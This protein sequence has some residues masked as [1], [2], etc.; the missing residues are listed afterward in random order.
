MG[1][2]HKF[3]CNH[4]WI[5]TALLGGYLVGSLQIL[6]TNF[7]THA[8]NDPSQSPMLPAAVWSKLC[9]LQKP[10]IHFQIG[11]S[12]LTRTKVTRFGIFGFLVL[13]A[14]NS[15]KSEMAKFP[16]CFLT[17]NALWYHLPTIFKQ[18]YMQKHIPDSTKYRNFFE[19]NKKALPALFNSMITGNQKTLQMNQTHTKVEE[20]KPFPRHSRGPGFLRLS[21]ALPLVQNQQKA[22]EMWLAC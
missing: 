14:L 20:S 11:E 17:T 19:L 21:R 12:S 9:T 3:C 10:Y 16:T 13:F 2:R 18:I 6:W 5:H 7:T 15:T 8:K 1:K 22:T 4:W